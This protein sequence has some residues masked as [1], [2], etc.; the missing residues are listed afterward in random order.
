MRKCSNK[1]A[2]EI[3]GLSPY[4]QATIDNLLITLDGTENFSNLGANATLGVSM[5]VAR[6]AAQSLN[7]PLYRYLGEQMLLHCLC[8]C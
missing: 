7:I 1:I 6:V 2:E 5:A 3:I 8:L 4:D